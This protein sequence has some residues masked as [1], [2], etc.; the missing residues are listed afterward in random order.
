M[1]ICPPKNSLKNDGDVYLKQMEATSL[2]GS[3][4]EDYKGP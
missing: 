1:H 3:Q 2:E 4:S